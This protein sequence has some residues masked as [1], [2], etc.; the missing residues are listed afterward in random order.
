MSECDRKASIK[1]RTWSTGAVTPL[2]C[3]YIYIHI[4]I[5][6]FIYR[7]TLHFE[8]YVVH[9]PTNALFTNLVKSFKFTL[10][11]TI[12]LLLHVLVF[13]DH[14]QGALSVPN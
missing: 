12:T 13:N 1:R 9:S 14:H 6:L 3:I 11:Y 7:C 2:K 5:Y 8:I 10:K 4:F